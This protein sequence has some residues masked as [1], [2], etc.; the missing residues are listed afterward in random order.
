MRRAES[1]VAFH[2]GKGSGLCNC[3]DTEG[4]VSN[5]AERTAQQERRIHVNGRV[6]GIYNGREQLLK[7]AEEGGED[8]S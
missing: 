5:K 4:S 7:A 8:S 2:F 6:Q 3:R 1:Q